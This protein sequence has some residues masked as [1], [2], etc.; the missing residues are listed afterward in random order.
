MLVRKQGHSARRVNGDLQRSLRYSISH[1]GKQRL[2]YKAFRVAWRCCHTC[3]ILEVQF[4]FGLNFRIF[5]RKT[6]LLWRGRSKAS[7][8]FN[9]YF[10]APPNGKRSKLLISK[11]RGVRGREG[12]RWGEGGEAVRWEGQWLPAFRDLRPGKS[13]SSECHYNLSLFY[14]ACSDFPGGM[15]RGIAQWR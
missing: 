7:H 1:Q 2:V 14:W 4:S 6:N 9:S 8:F 11:F 13:T 10:G 5:R 3:Q 12:Q 15:Q